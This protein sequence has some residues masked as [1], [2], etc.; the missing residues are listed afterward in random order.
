MIKKGGDACFIALFSMQRCVWI[1][2]VSFLK[3]V[4]FISS[5]LCSL[6]NILEKS[7]GLFVLEN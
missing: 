4:L 2:S 7:E 1:I 3:S 6:I 5:Q